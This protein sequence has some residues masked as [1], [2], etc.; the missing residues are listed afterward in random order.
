MRKMTGQSVT[1]RW[2]RWREEGVCEYMVDL[3]GGQWLL[4]LD[5]KFLIAMGMV[6]A[7]E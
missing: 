5:A 6:E 2:W 1:Q 4:G 7:G 3:H